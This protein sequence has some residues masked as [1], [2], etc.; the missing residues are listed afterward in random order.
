MSANPPVPPPPPGGGIPPTPPP[1]PGGGMPPAMPSGAGPQVGDGIK[2]AFN[3]FGQNAGILIAFAAVIMV[4]QFLG[5]LARNATSTT[6]DTFNDCDGLTG[7]ALANCLLEGPDSVGFVAGMGILSILLGILF[8]V[9]ATIAQIGLINASLKI[10]RG[11]KPEFSDL[12]NPRHFWQYAFVS[13]LLG[14]AV[15]FGLV[16]CIIPGLLAIWAWQFAQYSALD[17]GKGVFASFGE[18]WRMVS[19]NK[20]TA[21]IT[22]VVVAVASLITVITCGFG[23]LVVAPFQTLFI[24]NMYRQFR[25][26]PLAA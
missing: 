24:A 11:E 2:W 19:A 4:V 8:W 18:S 10:T 16:L 7:E 20:S 12:W 13:I 14:L 5:Y 3:K 1:P 15:G 17:T 6:V 9:L 23:A 26:E 25:N 21:V 22:L